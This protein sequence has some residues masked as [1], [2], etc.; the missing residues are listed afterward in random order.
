M[1]QKIK[2]ILVDDHE[3]V[4]GSAA[5][6]RNVHI[7]QADARQELERGAGRPRPVGHGHFQRDMEQHSVPC[8]GLRTSVGHACH[9]GGH[10]TAHPHRLQHRD[11]LHV[12]RHGRDGVSDAAGG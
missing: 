11:K 7:H 12:P 9:G 8:H 1:T 5:A 3:M 10:G 4:R 2:V 6:H